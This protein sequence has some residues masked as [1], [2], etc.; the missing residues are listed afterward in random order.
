MK[1]AQYR[2]VTAFSLALAL[3]I[4]AANPE[5]HADEIRWQRDVNQVVR[6]ARVSG[7][8]ILI[9][10]TA[11]WCHYCQKMKQET[12][13]DPR[14]VSAVSSSFEALVIDGDRNAQWVSQLGVT[15]FPTTLLYSNDGIL[16]GRKAG[17]MGPAEM[18]Q[19]LKSSTRQSLTVESK[20]LAGSYGR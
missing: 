20:I 15:G 4:S 3:S 10:V 18:D 8:P 6:S 2:F 12:L 1:L 7:K 5:S 19:W 16:L 9:F 14:L 13:R 17:F 11:Q